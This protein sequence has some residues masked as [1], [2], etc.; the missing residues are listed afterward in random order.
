MFR[1]QCSMTRWVGCW[2]ATLACTAGIALAT[3]AGPDVETTE[4]AIHML[5]RAVNAQPDGGHLPLLF[6]LRQLRDPDL[7]PLFYQ[8]AQQP[9]W[10]MQVHAVLGLGEIDPSKHIDPWLITQ[11]TPLAQEQVVATGLDLDLI[12]RDQIPEILKWEKLHS[13]ARMFLLSEL[14]LLKEPID[15]NELLE[16]TKSDDDHIAG[17]CA[18]LL[19]QLGN[20]VPLTAFG[21]RLA[22]LADEPRKDV[23]IW[24]LEA[25]RRYHL[26][27]CTAWVNS[28]LE[29]ST[30]DTDV[31]YRGIYTL[32]DL[33]PDAGIQQWNRFLG[34]K[35]E[36]SQRVRFGM[37]LLAIGPS[38]PASA[39]DRLLVDSSEE[40]IT[41]MVAVGKSISEKAD[42]SEPLNQLLDL[43]HGKT[44]NWAMDFVAKLPPQ[45]AA[46][47]YKHMIDRLAGT[48]NE[49]N[50]A[51]ALAVQSTSKLFEIDQQ[52]VLDRLRQA[53]DDS[54]Q[55]QAILLGLFE[56]TSP[57]A[58]QAAGALRRIGSGRADS[59]AFLLMA[60]HSKTLSPGDTEQLGQIAAGAGRVSDILQIQAAWMYLKHTGQV[61]A[62]LATVFAAGDSSKHPATQPSK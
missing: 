18:G 43:G 24:L 46:P 49:Q 42:P 22:A 27:A 39:Y 47:V 52:A 14:V 7:K 33:D 58:G 11:I 8:L 62:A 23:Q 59:L 45:Q 19:A 17:L 4:I 48:A 2:S 6:A 29:E 9:D 34:E 20:A 1:L 3:T 60:K 36:Y 35:P 53:E 30:V 13:M 21:T 32:L 51:V 26:I 38:V 57:A 10:Q 12:S 5:G 54:L 25:I 37:V 28:L 41:K 56:T 16:L 61:Q 44:T 50:N 31:A 15:Q 55:Q 40:L